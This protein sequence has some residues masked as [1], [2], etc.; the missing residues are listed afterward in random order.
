V[1]ESHLLA[2]FSNENPLTLLAEL[3]ESGLRKVLIYS[4]LEKIS[5]KGQKPL[6]WWK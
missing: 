3:V 2:Y 4:S 6:G 5:T 1:F